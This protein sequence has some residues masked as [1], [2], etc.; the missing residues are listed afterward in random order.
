METRDAG[1][2]ADAPGADA[3]RWVSARVGAR[4]YRAEIG[5]RSHTVVAD[6]PAS[7]GGSDEGPT[8]YELLLASLSACMAMTMRMYADRKGWPL[9]G[10]EVRLRTAPSRDPD[11]EVPV[12][13]AKAITCIERRIELTGDLTD[14]Q[15]RRIVEIADRCPVKRTLEGGLQLVAAPDDGA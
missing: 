6:E 10:A 5:A 1:A 13:G 9:A 4:G 14:E 7:L 3:G 2:A 8:P 12:V 11:R 15:R